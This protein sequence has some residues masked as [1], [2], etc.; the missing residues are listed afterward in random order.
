MEQVGKRE[1]REGRTS[2][3][4][5][6]NEMKLDSLASLE[7]STQ[8]PLSPGSRNI[9]AGDGKDSW[10][11]VVGSYLSPHLGPVPVELEMIL[12]T[13]C[14]RSERQWEVPGALHGLCSLSA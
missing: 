8:G 3:L 1:C 6:M 2:K 13:Q 5:D 7:H 10:W 9:E 12:R 4:L 11:E 14:N